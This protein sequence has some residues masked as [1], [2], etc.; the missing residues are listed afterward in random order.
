MSNDGTK[1]T[2]VRP[3]EQLARLVDGYLNTQLIYV[4][5][6]LGIAD[7]L[8]DGPRASD[9]LARAVDVQP[10]A[11]HRVL[12]GLAAIGVLDEI[13]D[14]RLALTPSGALL[15]DGVPG[16][17]RGA[18]LA[19]GGLY[20]EVAAG[21]LDAVREGGSAF[22]RFRGESFFG[23][24]AA[25]P[26]ESAV[27]QG[28]MAARSVHEAAAV[29]AIYD[30]S[31]FRRLI[32]VGGGQGILLAAI[33]Q[34]APALHGTLLDRPD[35]VEQARRRLEAADVIGRWTLVDGDFFAAIPTGGDCYLLSRVIH[36]WDDEAARRI[37]RRCHEAMPN[38][39]TLLLVEAVLP[40]RAADQPAA[41]RM[42][43]HMLTLLGGRE[44]TE[45]EYRELLAAAGFTLERVM[46]TASPAGICVLEARADPSPG[47]SPSH[48]EGST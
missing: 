8:A 5:T 27:F 9:D 14:S 3:E 29:V 41:I 40:E 12:R 18:V 45:T 4:A 38:D 13:G 20:Y 48:G 22:E 16:S 30:F 19:R 32:D 26:E 7:A 37:L 6:V 23:Y 42:D 46:P 39:G 43:L 33:L 15:R 31:R 35:A 47:S 24:L 44:R 25:H 21:L 11:L 1:F 36:D 34:A 10:V 2:N 17:M 28:S